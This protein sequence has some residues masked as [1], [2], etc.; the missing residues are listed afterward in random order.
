MH[1]ETFTGPCAFAQFESWQRARP[2]GAPP[3]DMFEGNFWEAGM[4]RITVWTLDLDEPR[5][6]QS[7][8]LALVNPSVTKK[9]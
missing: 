4:P 5:A 9:P 3:L 1:T 6:F 8:P 7:V 2:Q